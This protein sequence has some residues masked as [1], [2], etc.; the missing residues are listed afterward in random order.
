MRLTSGNAETGKAARPN[1]AATSI[2]SLVMVPRSSDAARRRKAP[3]SRLR[4]ASMASPRPVR[5][6]TAI[7]A[8]STKPTTMKITSN[9]TLVLPRPSA[10]TILMAPMP[11]RIVAAI[12]NHDQRRA[13]AAG[14]GS[15]RNSSS[16]AW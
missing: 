12:A 9:S 4:S 11:S 7:P 16:R 15:S 5:R 10:T 8:R 13:L 1:T 3:N 6:R 2:A 14:S